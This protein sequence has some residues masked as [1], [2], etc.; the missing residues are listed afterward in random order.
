MSVRTKIRTIGWSLLGLYQSLIAQN[1]MNEAAKYKPQ[2]MYSFS[3][4]EVMPTV[5]AY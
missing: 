4:A 3:H 5:S 1:K 2:Y